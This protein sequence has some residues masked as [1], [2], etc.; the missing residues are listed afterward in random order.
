M[1]AP[2]FIL[3]LFS[4]SLPFPLPLRPWLYAFSSYPDSPSTSPT[5]FLCRYPATP[6]ICDSLI[7]DSNFPSHST[8]GT[9]LHCH[10]PSSAPFIC[11]TH[12]PF[13]FSPHSNP[14]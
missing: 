9:C 5:I 1:S 12:F 4:F 10:L 3:Y 13:R 7:C 6:L 11:F 2:V 8:P 14:P